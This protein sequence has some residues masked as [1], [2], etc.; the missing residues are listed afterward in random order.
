MMSGHDSN[1]VFFNKKKR[2]IGRPEHLLT[3]QHPLPTSDYISFLPY[4][5]PPPPLF[6]PTPI[7]HPSSKWTS[8]VCHLSISD[9]FE[10]LFLLLWNRLRLREEFFKLLI[11]FNCFTLEKMIFPGLLKRKSSF[12]SCEIRIIYHAREIIRINFLL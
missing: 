6:S 5:P 2:T 3:S 9:V 11:V 12:K 4:F 7:P 1:P 8:Y 10:I